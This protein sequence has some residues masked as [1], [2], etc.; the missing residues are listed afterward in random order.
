MTVCIVEML[1]N[2]F[3]FEEGGKE[4]ETVTFRINNISATITKV[5]GGRKKNPRGL[6][7][8]GHIW[9][10]CVCCIITIF[11]PH[12][13]PHGVSIVQLKRVKGQLAR[14]IEATVRP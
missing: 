12:T 7:K 11:E 9:P 3:G 8:I 4:G 1:F 6:Y 5:T 14:E 10:V 13:V 2:I